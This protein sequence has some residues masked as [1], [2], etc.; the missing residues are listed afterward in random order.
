[1]KTN[2]PSTYSLCALIT[3]L[4]SCLILN[5][6]MLCNSGEVSMTELTRCRL[7]LRETLR[8]L[9]RY[10]PDPKLSVDF[11]TCGLSSLSCQSIVLNS[12]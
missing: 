5:V 6:L 3:D 11:I 12:L 7:H 4:L 10:D 9:E 1:M 8:K 2:E